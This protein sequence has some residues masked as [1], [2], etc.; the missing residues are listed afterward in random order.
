MINNIVNN[1]E[2]IMNKIISVILSCGVDTVTVDDV[3]VGVGVVTRETSNKNETIFFSLFHIIFIRV[4][5]EIDVVVRSPV[6]PFRQ[7]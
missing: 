4:S 7:S 2:T 5:V 1:N 6:I 3:V